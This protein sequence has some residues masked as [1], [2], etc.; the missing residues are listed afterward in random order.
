MEKVIELLENAIDDLAKLYDTF[1]EDS[2][3]YNATSKINQAIAELQHP[4]P[5]TPE[6]YRESEGEEYPDDGAVYITDGEDRDDMSVWLLAP[7]KWAKII[8]KDWD[9]IVCAY[10][11]KG[12][13]D[14]DWRPE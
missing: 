5:L 11:L 3:T 12:P 6:Q 2:F 14:P 8:K 10:N 9:V 7:Y 1:D 4:T 13:P